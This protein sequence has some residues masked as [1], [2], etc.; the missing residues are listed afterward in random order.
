M[1]HTSSLL[2]RRSLRATSA[3][4]LAY[5]L[6]CAQVAPLTL[7]AAPARPRAAAPATPVTPAAPESAAAPAPQPLALVPAV[8]ATKTDSFPDPNNNQKAEPGDIITYTVTIKNG[9]A[10]TD[11]EGVT[12]SDNLDPNTTLVGTPTVAPLARNDAYETFGNTLLEVGVA[13]SGNPA[14]RVTDTA[15]DSVFDNDRE[16]AGDTFSFDAVTQNPTKGTLTFNNDGTFSYQPNAGQTGADAFKYR[17]KDPGGLTDEATVTITIN[18]NEI[19]YVKNNV[20]GPGTGTSSDPFKALSAA[21]TASGAGDTVYV[22]FGDGTTGSQNTGITLD[23][24]QRLIGE[25]VQLDVP[26]SVNGGPN[27]TV[28]RAA[29][30]KPSITSTSVGTSGVTVNSVAGVQIRGLNIGGNTNAVSAQFAAAGGG[31]TITN[32]TLTGGSG[33]AVDVTTSGSG[34]A[35]VEI[36]NNIVAGAGSEGIDINGGG[37]GTTTLSLH[38]N[39][40]TATGNGID[41]NRGSSGGN[42]NVTAFDDNTVAGTTGGSGIVVVGSGSTSVLFDANPGTAAFDAVSWGVTAVGSAGAGNGAGA[43]GVQLT[44]VRGDLTFLDLDAYAD[45]G[46]ALLAVGTSPNYTG[47]SGTRL[48][49][50]AGTPTLVATGGAA[51]NVTDANVN[52]VASTLSSTNSAASGVALTR[53]GGTFTAPSGSTITNATSADFFVDGDLNANADVDVTYPGTITDDTGSLVTVTDVTAGS[54][55]TFSGAITDNFDGDGGEAGITL[56]GNTG[57]NITFSGGLNIRTTSNAAFTATNS[58]TLTI[59]DPA[60][61]PVNKLQSTT[62]HAL[63]VQ[64]TTIGAGGLTF[65]SI[66]S[67]GG[68]S[69][70]IT[71]DTT[72]AG[73][74]TIQGAGGSCTEVTPTCTGGII[75]NKGGSDGSSATQGTGIYMNGVSGAV[76][77]TLLKIDGN[78]NYGIRG[79]NV[80]GGLSLT[81][82]LVGVSATNGTSVS[83][84]TEPVTLITGEGSLRFRNLMGTVNFTGVVFDRG[85]GRTVFIHNATAGSTLNLTVANSTLRESLN[86]TNGGDINGGTSDAMFLQ[87]VSNAT[88]N[89][90]VTNCQFTAFRQFGILTDAQDTSTMNIE[91]ANSAFSNT[92]TGAA[93]AHASLNFSGTGAPGNDVFVKYNVHDNTFRHGSGATVPTNGGAHV[94]SGMVSGGGK[95]D[96]KVVS[97]TIGVD[98]VPRTGAG[99]AADALRLFASGNKAASTRV[100]GVTG[101]RYLVQGNTIQNYGEVGIQFNARQGNSTIDATVLGNVIRQPGAA[102]QGAFGSIWVNSGAL[103]P[104]TNIVNIA[105]GDAANAANKNTLTNSDPSNATDVFL[106]GGGNCGGCGAKINLYQNGSDAAGATAEAKARDVLVDDNVGPLDLLTGFTAGTITFV[107]G[108]PSQVAAMPSMP[109]ANPLRQ[110]LASVTQPA[111]Q[112]EAPAVASVAPATLPQLAERT[113][114]MASIDGRASDDSQTPSAAKSKRDG[115]TTFSHTKGASAAPLGGDAPAA[116]TTKL[117]PAPAAAFAGENI[118]LNLGTLQPGDEVVITF[119]AQ[120]ANPYGGP[121]NVSNQGSVSGTNFSTVLTDDS[122]NNAGSSDPTLTPINIIKMAVRDAVA[123]EPPTGSTNMIFTVTLSNPPAPM[124]TVSVNFA[125]ADDTTGAHPA[126]AGVDYSAT[127]GTVTF[128][129]GERVK[130]INVPVLGNDGQSP[131]DDETFLVNL[132]VPATG[133][134]VI[135]AQAVGTIRQ[136]TPAS[137]L[138]ISELRTSGPAGSAD[139]FVEIYNNTDA[140]IEINSADTPSGYGLYKMGADCT[141]SMELV[142]VIPNGTKIPARGHFLLVGSAYSL[143]ALAAGDGAGLTADIENDRNVGLF[144]TADIANVSSL[145]RLDAVGFGAN[146]QQVCDLLRE[147]AGLTPMAGSTLEYTFF[148]DECG[149][150]GSIT[151]FGP[152]PT[153]GEYADFNNNATDFVFADTTGVSTPAGQRLGTPGPQNLAS[154]IV[155]NSTVPA[156][157]LDQSQCANCLP[158]RIRTMGNDG[159]NTNGTI[160]IRKRVV[161]NTTVP[162][163]KLRF[164]IIDITTKPA[165]G[166]ADVR[167]RTS[168]DTPN[169]QIINDPAT[170]GNVSGACTITVKG[171]TIG[172]TPAQPDGG[173]FNATWT[174]N[175]STPL[176]PGQSVNIQI[177]LGVMQGGSYRFLFNTEAGQ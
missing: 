155:R 108:L 19:W 16:F 109:D 137:P 68:T 171:T 59:T 92:N 167:A 26:V 31:V 38:D 106:D 27:P 84:D 140:E 78:Q 64:N 46:S 146:N 170:C 175:L 168:G 135:R 75:Q 30:S 60:G 129:P 15:K 151:T 51:A 134:D 148:R 80:T 89:L 11:A 36:G 154:P 49:I 39:A 86:N 176:Q 96:G 76:T 147:G 61:A 9:A 47:T 37:S 141:G 103:P 132:T 116:A 112:K 162:L 169:V 52:I 114:E 41:V 158:N 125:T 130:T 55:Y 165:P 153:G 173:G 156:L 91:V 48:T 23:A 25:G 121:A 124:T 166:T 100:T 152:C 149:K 98:G 87:S 54:T 110:E 118:T 126:T 164:R 12:F 105:I 14:V 161:N 13:A 113:R 8:T 29:G 74:F 111:Q 139:D 122:D 145:N 120:V 93:P 81:N 136:T 53:V 70:G 102:A 143:G 77:L 128:N 73:P 62:G 45:N 58:G 35:A 157:Q 7:A 177:V 1:N 63:F 4:L 127:S 67:N 144:S 101:T 69:N 88:M 138:I 20:T 82:S 159:T 44:N 174:V 117:S 79:I 172:T 83:P 42:L 163:N 95:F 142:G 17:I 85:F 107:P 65:E 115:G 18:A 97:N 24:N 2:R 57:L 71:L 40:V 6:L 104:D 32:N 119:Q 99:N 43:N 10:A 133:A 21:D 94:V 66:S 131:E 50:N 33:N 160:T 123:T 90:T 150:S 3:C 22:F 28:L 5:L 34:G 72:G 56:T